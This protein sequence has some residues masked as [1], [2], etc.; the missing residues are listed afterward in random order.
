MFCPR[1]CYFTGWSR[2]C[3]D[4][5]ADLHLP[6]IIQHHEQPHPIEYVMRLSDYKQAKGV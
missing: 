2:K 4:R 5:E 3:V 1:L 6:L